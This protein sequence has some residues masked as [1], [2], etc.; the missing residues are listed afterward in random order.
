MVEPHHLPAELRPASPLTPGAPLEKNTLKGMEAD[1]I[2][3]ALRR[4][5]W[6]RQAAA[7]ELGIHKTT[8]FRKIAAL[9]IV[10]PDEDGRSHKR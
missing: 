2:V 10:L 4:N 3:A 5:D 9:G 8:L 7:D 6:H 1:A